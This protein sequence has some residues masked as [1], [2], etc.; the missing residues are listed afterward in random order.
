MGFKKDLG[1]WDVC[2]S[3]LIQLVRL[4]KKEIW[5]NSNQYNSAD[6]YL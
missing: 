3:N 1:N 4:H 5:N 6:F 2:E